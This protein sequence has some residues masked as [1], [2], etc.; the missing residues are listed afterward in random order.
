MPMK[1]SGAYLCY[2]ILTKNPR[3]GAFRTY[4]GMSNN[5]DRRLRQHNSVIVG[6][7]RYT[8]G[9][10]PWIAWLTIEGVEGRGACM[11]LERAIKTQTKKCFSS[12]R[13]PLSRRLLAVIKVL[14]AKLK[15]RGRDIDMTRVKVHHHLVPA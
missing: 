3:T 9:R 10:G 6:G 14:E 5:L 13:D 4:C 8:R 15:H 11:V 2:I 1:D 7:A 12:E